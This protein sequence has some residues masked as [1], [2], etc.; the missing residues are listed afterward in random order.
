[1]FALLLTFAISLDAKT[2]FDSLTG[3]W[4]VEMSNPGQES[5]ENVHFYVRVSQT[6]SK[7]YVANVFTEIDG[8][9]SVAS[10]TVAFVDNSA[11]SIKFGDEDEQTVSLTQAVRGHLSA[12]GQFKELVFSFNFATSTRMHLS[13]F[14]H[15]NGEMTIYNFYKDIQPVS[16]IKKYGFMMLSGVAMV[17]LQVF[18]YFQNK[19]QPAQ[20][21]AQQPKAQQKNDKKSDKKATPKVE[22]VKE[23]EKKEEK[24][25]DDNN[26]E[27]DEGTNKVKTD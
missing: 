14:N 26:E 27:E 17:G 15:D 20:Q 13:T 16:F 22:E 6:P 23:N 1:M 21:P 5:N 11:L 9:E 2:V 12:V 25:K 10:W 3:N 4:T 7:E 18:N 24:E 8:T 19:Q